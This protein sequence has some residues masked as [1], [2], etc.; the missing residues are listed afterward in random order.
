VSTGPAVR[1]CV[2]P[3]GGVS[4][5]GNRVMETP[6]S[7]GTTVAR[8]Q[9]PRAVRRSR[10]RAL[11][12][13]AK[14]QGIAKPASLPEPIKSKKS[15]KPVEH[16]RTKRPLPVAAKAPE[17]AIATTAP[18]PLKPAE[19]T[20]RKRALPVAA[21]APEPAIAPKAPEPSRPAE[22]KER[23]PALPVAAKAPE[24]TIA[25]KAP[26]AAKPA[27]QTKRRWGLRRAPKAPKPAEPIEQPQQS[28]KE[29]EEAKEPKPAPLD[30]L[31]DGVVDWGIKRD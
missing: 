19:H 9:V 5:M 20:E 11:R 29:V 7:G 18:R 6:N 21:K 22:H 16:P 3:S 26:E 12:M 15:A 30:H 1:A 14:A 28:E 10:K 17:P 25:P 27:E 31:Q 13:A 4:Q 2:V 24:P 23:T 8:H